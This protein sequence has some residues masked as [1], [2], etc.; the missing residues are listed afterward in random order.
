MRV[1]RC[2]VVPPD[3]QQSGVRDVLWITAERPAQR[4]SHGGVAGLG[5][6]PPVEN[7]RAQ[8]IE[9]SP[10]TGGPMYDPHGARVAVRYD[11]LR[12]PA[13]DDRAPPRGDLVERVVP[14]HALEPRG[15]FGPDAPHGMHEPSRVRVPLQILVTLAA[16][17]PA[18]DWMFRITH[19]PDNPPTLDGR[20]D[21]AAIRA[22]Q[23]ANRLDD[24]NASAIGTR[25]WV[26]HP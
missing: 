20:D 23:G 24:P 8:P 11:R 12:P 7:R 22:V 9:E 21:S 3:E 13:F 26:M 19:R 15:A 2:W 4:S 14:G 18:G 5:A 6:D 16:E 1:G 17:P 10:L 25:R